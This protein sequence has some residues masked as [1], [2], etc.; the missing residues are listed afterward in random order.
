VASETKLDQNCIEV[1]VVS[2]DSELERRKL[3]GPYLL[4]LD[5]HGFEVPILK[6]AIETL[7][8]LV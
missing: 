8:M 3:D 1:P 5:I 7:K 2:I 4:K 6:G